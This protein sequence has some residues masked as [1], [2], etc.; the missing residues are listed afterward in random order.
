[1][2][3]INNELALLGF[4]YF[5]KIGPLKLKLLENYF[6]NFCEAFGASS[7]DLEKAGLKQKLASE[8]IS[9]RQTF[10]F[11]KVINELRQE[12]IN[13]ITYDD[14]NYPNLLKEISSPPHLLY[15]KGNIDSL[16]DKDRFRLAI[17]GARK[18]SAYGEKVIN[19]LIPDL[20]FNNI[21]IVSGLALGIDTLAHQKTLDN[22]GVTLAVLGTGL[23]YKN[24]YPSLNRQLAQKIISSN[25][26]LISEFPPGT[27]PLKQNF[28]QRNRIISG[29]CQATLVIEA[30]EKSGSLITA[31]YALDQNREVLAIPGNI[32]SDYSSGTN[33]LVK[34]GAKTILKVADILEVFK[35]ENPE[36]KEKSSL[37]KTKKEKIYLKNETEK[38]VYDILKAA[39][40]KSEALTTNEI[41]KISK[42]DTSV[43]NSTLSI[44]ELQ[45]IVKTSEMGYYIN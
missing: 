6:P 43:I 5:Q 28:P 10:N 40:E 4:N 2:K 41:I 23:D 1:M 15:Y 14:K 38:L 29:L 8:F 26:L 42:L 45:G 17:V 20:I 12:N 18:H 19:E 44:L 35:I 27:Q 37:N 7:Y 13:F 31:H 21:E 24:L 25:G 32:F 16:N 36:N 39:G 34:A 30:Q 3:N 33:N 9:W 22:K 11:E